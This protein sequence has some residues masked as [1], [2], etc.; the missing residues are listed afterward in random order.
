M[1]WYLSLAN[2]FLYRWLFLRKEQKWHP[3]FAF[4]NLKSLVSPIKSMKTSTFCLQ[5]DATH[6]SELKN[7]SNILFLWIL[8]KKLRN[9]NFEMWSWDIIFVPFSE[10]VTCNARYGIFLADN[11]VNFENHLNLK[12]LDLEFHFF[13]GI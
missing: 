13:P 2:W 12:L 5:C 10:K 11:V 4:Q 6:F 8:L 3:N 9:S 1:I 7:L